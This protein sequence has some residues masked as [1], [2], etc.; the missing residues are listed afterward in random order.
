MWA[1]VRKK[2]DADKVHKAFVQ[3]CHRASALDYAARRYRRIIDQQGPDDEVAARGL[4]RIQNMA[5]ATLQPRPQ[6]SAL[7]TVAKW[8][9]AA[10]L[11]IGVASGTVWVLSGLGIFD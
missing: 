2:Y 9:G 4:A 10:L 8:I 6:T 1:Q 7:G 3:F 5:F 11:L